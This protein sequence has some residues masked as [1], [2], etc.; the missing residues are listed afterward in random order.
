[1]DRKWLEQ[2][3]ANCCQPGPPHVPHVVAPF[4]RTLQQRQ[5][6]TDARSGCITNGMKQQRMAVARSLRM[7]A[8]GL[9]L[10][11]AGVAQEMPPPPLQQLQQQCHPPCQALPG[12]KAYGPICRN[13]T[14]HSECEATNMTCAWRVTNATCVCQLRPGASPAYRHFCTTPAREFNR[15]AC[16]ALA[17]TCTFGPISSWCALRPGAPAPYSAACTA[18]KTKPA[19]DAL[20]KACFWTDGKGPIPPPGPSPPPGPGPVPAAGGKNRRTAASLAVTLALAATGVALVVA[21]GAMWWRGDGS[22]QQQLLLPRAAGGTERQRQGRGA[23]TSSSRDA[24]AAAVVSGG[25][26]SSRTHGMMSSSSSKPGSA[27]DRSSDSNALNYLAA[28]S[29]SSSGGSGGSQAGGGGIQ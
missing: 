18:A 10:S 4:Y 8:L 1:M 11:A 29:Y 15:S 20:S 24:A 28:A 13:E 9:I 16:A 14:D 12:A 6:H 26:G 27:L 21:G 22:E 5:M 3:S 17:E 7:L 25:T 2:S 19:C 23:S